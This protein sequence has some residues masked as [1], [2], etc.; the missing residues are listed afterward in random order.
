LL[1][2]RYAIL[3]TNGIANLPTEVAH[4]T[5]FSSGDKVQIRLT[6]NSAGYLY[7]LRYESAGTWKVIFPA[8]GVNN[9]NNHVDSL[10]GM[11]GPSEVEPFGPNGIVFNDQNGT[12]KLFVLFSRQPELDLEH[13]IYSE[14]LKPA[15]E[16]RAEEPGRTSKQLVAAADQH[17][18]DDIVSRLR[19]AYASGLI[20][21]SVTPNPL[22]SFV[23]HETAVYA[24][25]PTRS[26][27][28]RVVFD[29]NLVHR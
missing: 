14:Q 2:V 3:K 15:T 6:S 12:E 19:K 5:V 1:G 13:K 11:D 27:S 10:S 22:K 21:G 23:E 9:G 4:D 8:P 25:N 24:V 29:V 26:L 16:Q 18:G 28:A 17:I 20:V 7:V